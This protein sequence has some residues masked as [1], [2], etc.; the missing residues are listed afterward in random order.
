VNIACI[1]GIGNL[2]GPSTKNNNCTRPVLFIYAR[3]S[4]SVHTVQNFHSLVQV[5]RGGYLLRL[6]YFTRADSFVFEFE[7][8]S[9]ATSNSRGSRFVGGATRAGGAACR[10]QSQAAE[11]VF[12]DIFSPDLPRRLSDSPSIAPRLVKE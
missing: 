3:N 5:G 9:N 8:Q 11:I 1:A 6:M 2:T 10:I 7:S 12:V 4:H